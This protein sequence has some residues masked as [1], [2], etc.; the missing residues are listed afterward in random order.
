[1]AA[2]KGNKLW[3]AVE[4][5]GLH[6]INVR[7]GELLAFR[8]STQPG[9]L[10]SD[11]VRTLLL[12]NQDRLWVGTS[13]GLC[14]FDI[15]TNSFLVWTHTP[16][17]SHS[18]PDNTILSIYQDHLG[19]MWAGTEQGVASFEPRANA[20]VQPLPKQVTGAVW[21]IAEDA[22]G[23][24]WLGTETQGL[25]R[26]DP[27]TGNYTNYQHNP[28]DPQSLPGNHIRAIWPD[29]QGRIWVGTQ[30]KGLCYLDPA[31][32]RFR[33]FRHNPTDP[34]SLSDNTILCIFQD[35]RSRLWVG[36]EGGLNLFDPVTGR[37][38][39]Y[40][41]DPRDTLDRVNTLSLSS[42]Y[43]RCVFEDSQGQLWLGVGGGGLCRFDPRTGH[44]RS[45]RADS[46]DPQS[47]SSNY[48]RCMLE[49]KEGHLWLAT[50]G[51]GLCCML[52]KAKGL[53][54]TYREPQGLPNDVI[55][56]MLPDGQ[57]NLWLATNKGIARFTPST[58]RFRTY[59]MRDGLPQDE[60][61]AGAFCRRRTGSLLF[62]GGNGAVEFQPTA[63][64]YNPAPPVVVFTGFRKF[65]RAVS[66]D[67]S[68]TERRT[69]RLAPRDNFF[70]IDFAALNYRLPDKNR[71]AYMMENFDDDWIEAGTQ[72]QATYTNLD[73]GRYTFRVR[74]ANNDGVWN[75]TGASLTVIVDPPWYQTWWFRIMA[76]W[77]VF[78]LL[79]ALYRMRVSQLLALERV[80]H[81]IARDLHDDMGSTLSSISILSQLARTH[82][83]RGNPEQSSQL[84]E[85]IGDS[86]RRMLDSMDDIVWAINPAHDS[87]DSV[88]A[89]MRSFASDVLEARGIDFIFKVASEVSEH[90]L[91]MRA[92]R[93]FFLLFK[94]A[95]NNLAKYSKAEFATIRLDYEQKQLV[96][97]VEDN[98]VGFDP[99]APA[100][101]GGNG[102]TNM[103]SRAA[104]IKG[105]L[106]FDTAPGQGTKMELRV[107]MK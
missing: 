107:P 101:G 47:L 23:R 95:V 44:T 75:P 6:R 48:I 105:K 1:M 80:R 21:S 70:S 97:R 106:N 103:R 72:H 79:F 59:D 42:N 28:A 27:V 100:Q 66:L 84:L 68:I 90:R 53:F 22:G 69:L 99:K 87:M 98:G 83:Q 8:H 4:N 11:G 3:I 56:G 89:R 57:D 29:K 39:V 33:N 16:G 61:N 96:L 50:E 37:S 12:D 77:V 63:V 7:T 74:A 60:Y 18:L 71:F 51:G 65:N 49:D 62:G 64:R 31:T 30:R 94:E 46:D 78:G 5:T 85:Q 45:Y 20:F 15:E 43:V 58:Q 26:I 91:P 13:A 38:A 73:P 88:T 9:A 54:K 35:R 102:M 82:Q 2:S 81:N 41:H 14:R 32:G 76:S 52:D 104:A 24:L 36:T 34:T 92:R 67:T 17:A 19:L 86:S 55:Y 10:P 25:F 40:R 93:E